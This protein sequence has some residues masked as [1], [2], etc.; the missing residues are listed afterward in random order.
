MKAKIALLAAALVVG[1]APDPVPDRA[2]MPA[3]TNAGYIGQPLMSDVYAA[4]VAAYDF[5]SPE[6]TRGNPAEAARGVAALDYIVGTFWRNPQYASITELTQLQLVQA[7]REVRGVLGIAANARSQAVVNA[8]LGVSDALYANDAGRARA[9]LQPPVFGFGPDRT[10]A[11]L[12]NLP[13]MPT[14]ASAALR[15][16]LEA[17]GRSDRC[18]FIPC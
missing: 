1:C 3:A 4:E 7:R 11:M 8:M 18:N 9:L 13:A 17:Y 10:L 5:A 2:F 16:S 12:A 14:T 15:A 6:R